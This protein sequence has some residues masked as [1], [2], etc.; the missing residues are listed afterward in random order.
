VD[1]RIRLRQRGGR[2]SSRDRASPAGGVPLTD[3][4]SIGWRAP[5]APRGKE[6][7]STSRSIPTSTARKVRSSS[8][9]ISSSAKARIPGSGSLGRGRVESH[10]GRQRLRHP[11]PRR[12]WRE[13][14]A[15]RILIVDA[16][17]LFVDAV[18]PTL[19][20]LGA[21]EIVVAYNGSDGVVAAKRNELDIALVDIGLPDRS[22]LSVGREIMEVN[23]RIRVV[24]LTAVQDATIARTAL[25]LGF[26]AYLPKDISLD[27]FEEV[28]R[29]VL[30]GQRP[31]P[32]T[33]ERPMRDDE[34]PQKL[35]EPLTEIEEQVLELLVRGVNHEDIATTLDIVPDEVRTYVESIL[36]KLQVHSRLDPPPMP[37]AASMALAVPRLRPEDIPRHVGRRVPRRPTPA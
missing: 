26:A 16:H 37:P 33:A 28:L 7:Q 21:E 23:P 14:A 30:G 13:S 10:R 4:E 8:Q 18:L 29:N 36:M 9:S 17:A 35:V 6:T 27:S 12:R 11:A 19:Q 15:I 32:S 31:D 24:A 22:G 2:T 25:K 20:H 3:D 34:D 1:P 5:A